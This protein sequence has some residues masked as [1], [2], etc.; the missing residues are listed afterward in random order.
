MKTVIQVWTHHCYNMQQTETSNY[1]GIGDVLRGTI[2]MYM[3]SKKL[4]FTLYVDT[5]LHPIGK[6][7]VPIENPY[8]DLIQANKDKIEM[9]PASKNL[10]DHLKNINK[11]E[12]IYFCFTNAHCTEPFDEEC[13]AFIKR[14]LS[15]LPQFDKELHQI[16]PFESYQI[17][18]FRLGDDELVGNKSKNTSRCIINLI[19]QNKGINDVLISDSLSLKNDRDVQSEVY[20]LNTIPQHL[21]RCSDHES[22]RGTLTDFFLLSRATN[23]K[24][25]S[26]YEWTSGFAYWA[27]QIYDIPLSKIE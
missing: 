3:L 17:M 19:K 13:R 24:T 22:I 11:K 21:G 18:H 27:H 16:I 8:A 6:Y 14:I 15:P 7:L 4:G 20:V 1:W 9:V 10:E 25:Y 12:D 26:C 5:S 23:I 2:Q